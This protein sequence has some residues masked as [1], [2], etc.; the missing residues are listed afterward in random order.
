[1]HG[2]KGQSVDRRRN[3]RLVG[4]RFLKVPLNDCL[5]HGVMKF[6]IAAAIATVILYLADQNV[7]GGLYSRVVIDLVRQTVGV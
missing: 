1:M 7:S 3:T 5:D 6:L 4:P 2:P